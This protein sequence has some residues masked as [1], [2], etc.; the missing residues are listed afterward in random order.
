[1][2]SRDMIQAA[3]REAAWKGVSQ[4]GH[5]PTIGQFASSLKVDARTGGEYLRITYTDRDPLV[6]A[7]GVQSLVGAANGRMFA[8]TIAPRHS[9]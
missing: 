1:M 8:N 5:A 7:A 6:A 4:K 3:T 2:C 9:G